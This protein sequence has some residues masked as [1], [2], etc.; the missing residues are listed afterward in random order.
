MRTICS[1]PND[2]AT[3]TSANTPALSSACVKYASASLSCPLLFC[4]VK[5]VAAPMP[6]IRPLPWMKLY[7]GMA[8]FSAVRPSAPMPAETKNV[9]AR[10]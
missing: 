6:I 10:M 7:M 2:P 3:Q 8:R 9:S 4:I 1:A 5:R